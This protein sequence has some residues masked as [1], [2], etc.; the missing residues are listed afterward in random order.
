MSHRDKDTH[1][2]EPTQA[3]E[4]RAAPSKLLNVPTRDKR[5]HRTENLALLFDIVSPAFYGGP[6]QPNTE[7]AWIRPWLGIEGRSLLT[8]KAF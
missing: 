8:L 6:V 2:S 5:P 1:Y 3:R 4:C 7:R